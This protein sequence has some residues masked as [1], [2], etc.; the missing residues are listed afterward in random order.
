M[1][2]DSPQGESAFSAGDG[3]TDNDHR[4]EDAY[5]PW[6]EAILLVAKHYRMD[7]SEEK[8]RISAAWRQD[9]SLLESVNLIANQAGLAAR[10]EDLDIGTISSWRLPLVVQFDDGQV[11]VIESLDGDGQC[12]ICLVGDK[13]LRSRSSLENLRQ[14]VR[15]V[16]ILRPARSVPDARVDDYIKPHEPHW[17]RKLVFSD[18]RP[19]GHIFVA[20]FVANILALAAIIFSRQVYD[21]VIPAESLN[22]LYVLFSGVVLALL[23]DF[24]MR[25]ARMRVSD[26]LGKRADMKASDRVFGRSM[27]VKN[28]ARP[29]S[30]GSFITQIRELESVR[31][32]LTSTTVSGFADL[33]FFILFCVVFWY[34]GGMLVLVPIGAL[35]LLLA[36]GLLLQPK[37]HRLAKEAMRESS[38]RSGM[39]VEAIQGHEDIK[40]LQAESRFQNQWNHFNAVLADVNLKSRNLTNSLSSW[41]HIIQTGVFGVV[42]LFGAPMVMEGDLTVGTLVACS[43]LASRMMAPMAQFNTVLGRWQQAKVGLESLDNLMQM[44]ADVPDGENRIQLPSIRGDY[45]LEKAAFF[46]DEE[47]TQPA[48]AVKSLTIQAGEKIAVL[49]RNGSGKTT[50]IS[51]LAG[52]VESRSGQI[53]LDGVGLSHIDPADVRRDVALLSQSSRLFHGTIRENLQMAAV[54]ASDHDLLEA[55]KLSGAHDFVTRLADGLNHTMMEGGLG[56]SSGQRQ[57]LIFTRLILRD[58]SVVLMDEPTASLDDASETALIKNMEPWLATRTVVLTTHR[59]RVLSLVDRVLVINNG[60]VVMDDEKSKVLERLKTGK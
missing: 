11:G 48:L 8:I 25:R 10:I 12:S 57:M 23:F 24:I 31:E 28:N 41:A 47:A 51:A 52:L 45:Q 20:S 3:Q 21:R 19:Y 16:V 6:I 59:L 54:S 18:L 36:P 42:V 44:P 33:P 2:D 1:S 14:S 26:L 9:A 55:L 34:L 4:A 15:T 37:L 7:Y 58:P 22:T 53:T 40:M 30:T 60:Q 35:V 13:G 5:T 46:Y 50:L 39:L 56:L 49:G 17:F 32:L 38:L 29:K 27:R 43:I